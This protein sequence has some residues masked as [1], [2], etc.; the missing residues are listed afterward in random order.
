MA[1]DRQGPLHKMAVGLDVSNER[2]RDRWRSSVVVHACREEGTTRKKAQ[3]KKKTTND[4]PQH[5]R[6]TGQKKAYGQ[7]HA[8]VPG[9]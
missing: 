9:D 5:Q 8:M 2:N 3:R 1:G 6:R 4:T 7:G